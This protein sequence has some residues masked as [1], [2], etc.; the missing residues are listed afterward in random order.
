MA[1]GG[2]RR[3]A[4]WA[5]ARRPPRA[6]R[7]RPPRPRRCGGSRPGGWKAVGRRLGLVG[8]W[9]R[10]GPGRLR[11]DAAAGCGP[12]EVVGPHHSTHARPGT[13]TSRN[14]DSATSSMPSSSWLTELTWRRGGGRGR[15]GWGQG[16]RDRRSS[17]RE[18]GLDEAAAPGRPRP[19][20]LLLL[21]VP[22]F[23]SKAWSR[24]TTPLPPTPSP[25]PYAPAPTAPWT[26]PRA[27]RWSRGARVLR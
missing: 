3:A 17:R 9:G 14:R 1:K 25:R 13:P 11:I 7:R 10:A 12:W 24:R 18:E 19:L 27:S 15:E 21:G 23:P 16:V 2:R 4:L 26:P 5:R 20:R 6:P 22:S 8:G